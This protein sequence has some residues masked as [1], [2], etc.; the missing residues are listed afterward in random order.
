MKKRKLELN[1]NTNRRAAPIRMIPD[2]SIRRWAVLFFGREVLLLKETFLASIIQNRLMM[3][4][5][6]VMMIL[7]INDKS[8]N[9]AELIQ[10]A[11]FG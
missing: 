8:F 9:P 10:F 5:S 6:V 4:P 3:V 7:V 11:M 2:R 1:R